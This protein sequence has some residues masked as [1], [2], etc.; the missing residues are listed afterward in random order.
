MLKLAV[1]VGLSLN[2]GCLLRS[3]QFGIDLSRSLEESGIIHMNPAGGRATEFAC[4]A[5]IASSP[6]QA[7]GSAI[8]ARA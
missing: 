4:D 3:S 2:G 8:C 1:G 7:S 6:G 5:Q